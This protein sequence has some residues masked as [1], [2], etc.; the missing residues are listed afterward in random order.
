MQRGD[1]IW[2]DLST[3]NVESTKSFYAD[4]LGWKYDGMTQPDGS[5]YHIAMAA[6]GA[7][8][9][10]FE[11]PEKFQ[12]IGLPSFWMS[13]IAV[14]HIEQTIA[15]ARRL[16]GKVEVGPIPFGEGASI[17]LI[18]DPLGAG[19]TV[20]QGD[21]LGPPSTGTP[22]GHVAWNALYI[23]D[24]SAVMPFYQALFGWR[25]E[26]DPK[27]QGVFTVSSAT[28][29]AIAAI[30]QLPEEVRGPF[31]YWGA[32][33]AVPDLQA[34]KAQI[35]AGGGE[36]VSE[37]AD[38]HRPALLARDPDGAAFYLVQA[39]KG[40]A[41]RARPASAPA[42]FKWMT[43]LALLVL[44]V[45]VALEVNWVW[46][47]LFIMWTIPALKSGQAFLVEPIARRS[48]PVLFYLLIATWITLSLVLI[49]VDLGPVVSAML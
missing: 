4:L 44:W 20:Y 43:V 26:A 21:E 46:G 6:H 33:F 27:L 13:Y 19:F 37:D 23:S 31:Q 39:A 12:K 14:D 35:A 29:N 10:I 25:I 9:G 15:A 1:F 18:R 17:A 5:P 8:A 3:F 24:A 16:G 34:A 40:A 22:P 42:Q 41:N 45:A 47:A 36:I 11:M 49:V 32:H 7:S 2:C 38:P 28:G 48:H 30:H